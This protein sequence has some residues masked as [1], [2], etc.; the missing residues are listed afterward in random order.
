M[1]TVGDGHFYTE[2]FLSPGCPKTS[3]QAAKLGFAPSGNSQRALAA[4]QHHQDW[5]MRTVPDTGREHE[6]RQEWGFAILLALSSLQEN[7]MP[8]SKVWLVE[9]S[10]PGL[11]VDPGLGTLRRAMKPVCWH[12]HKARMGEALQMQLNVCNHQ[13]SFWGRGDWK[14]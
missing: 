6:E 7:D 2:T 9:N 4:R 3:S 5:W 12:A 8:T 14:I 11:V 13:V 10:T 1:Q